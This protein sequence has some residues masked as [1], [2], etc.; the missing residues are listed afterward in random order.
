MMNRLNLTL[1]IKPNSIGQRAVNVRS[2]LTVAN[3]IATIQ[4][5]FNIDGELMLLRP[6]S[7]QALSTEAGLDQLGIGDNST[8]TCMKIS[9][10]S[11]TLDAIQRA[12]RKPFSRKFTRVFVREQNTLFE[13]DLRWQPALIGRLDARDPKRNRL[14]AVDLEPFQ[15]S[16]TVS[17]HHACIT[18]ANGLFYIEDIQGRNPVYLDGKKIRYGERVPLSAGATL[19]IGQMTLIFNTIG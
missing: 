4:D 13:F 15:D 6:N 19:K 16:P 2:S 18:E 1:D 7:S 5:K 17:R 12:E 9:R 3:L 14:L 10:P 8:L 11:G